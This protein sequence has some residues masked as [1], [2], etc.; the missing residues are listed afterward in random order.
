MHHRHYR[1]NTLAH[2]CAVMKQ[3]S[4]ACPGS[5]FD[6]KIELRAIDDDLA[7]VYFRGLDRS[8]IVELSWMRRP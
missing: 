7:L 8:E 2:H 5:F 4:C 6:V 3:C 1:H